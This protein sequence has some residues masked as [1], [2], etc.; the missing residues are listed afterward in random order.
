MHLLPR[1]KVLPKTLGV[2]F[3]NKSVCMFLSMPEDLKG[4]EIY[5]ISRVADKKFLKFVKFVIICKHVLDF[6]FI[7][8]CCRIDIA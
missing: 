6:K 5:I 7:D 3:W 8:R 2:D 1:K 4:V